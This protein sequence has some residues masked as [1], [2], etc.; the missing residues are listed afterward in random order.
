MLAEKIFVK[1][2]KKKKKKINFLK[3]NQRNI[4]R[5]KIYKKV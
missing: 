1:S 2:Q 3:K 5:K 4:K